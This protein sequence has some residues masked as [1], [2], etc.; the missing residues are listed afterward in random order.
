MH[1]HPAPTQPA[2]R[3]VEYTN[4]SSVAP[5]IYTGY[6]TLD[7][8]PAHPYP[9][10]FSPQQY[11]QPPLPLPPPPARD[12]P[13]R[14]MS[15]VGPYSSP[16]FFTG[17]RWPAPPLPQHQYGAY[18]AQ[19]TLSPREPPSAS[20]ITSTSVGAPVSPAGSS[21]GERRT[22]VLPPP[23]PP[24]S[25]SDWVMWVGN[26]PRD[27]GHDEMWRFFAGGASSVAHGHGILSIFLIA[28]SGCAFVNYSS[29]AALS[30]AIAQ[31]DGV[32]LR[33][34]SAE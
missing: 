16:H 6:S 13:F 18:G 1:I 26:V 22:G 8:F 15:P 10:T 4:M 24:V 20:P 28:R 5:S 34:G 30:A 2:L 12:V 25:R 27:A 33:A 21:H 29:S 14:Y 3:V 31:F 17:H 11:P 23:T 32:P 7:T 9:A 19:Q